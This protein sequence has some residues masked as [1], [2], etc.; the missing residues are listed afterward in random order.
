LKKK[1]LNKAPAIQQNNKRKASQ[2]RVASDDESS[3]ESSGET[4][5]EELE[6][7]P[8]KKCCVKEKGFIDKDEVG[9]VDDEAM[10]V[11]E[12]GEDRSKS[13]SKIRLFLLQV[14]VN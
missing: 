6:A 12:D 9:D 13:D 5:G 4:S 7:R 3:G 8:R 11:D 14:T 10:Q 1:P 2:K